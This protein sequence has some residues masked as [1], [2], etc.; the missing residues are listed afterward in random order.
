MR[1]HHRVAFAVL[2]ALSTRSSEVPAQATSALGRIVG[3][4]A[5]SA[6]H[7][8]RGAHISIQLVQDPATTPSNLWFEPRSATADSSARFA[9]DS[10]P[11]G[12]YGIRSLMVGM[13]RWQDTVLVEES[14]TTTVAIRMGES[15]FMRLDRENATLNEA[16]WQPVLIFTD[17]ATDVPPCSPGLQASVSLAGD[18]IVVTGCEVFPHGF[19]NL[20]AAVSRF[21]SSIVLDIVPVDWSAIAAI[22]FERRYRAKILLR[23]PARYVLHVRLN[24]LSRTL[25]SE[26]VTTRIVDLVGHTVRPPQ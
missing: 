20:R 7:R 21:G 3:T 12:R 10:L 24:I 23:E 18:T 17:E 13:G 25:D 4:V 14:H 19:P 11:P 8:L 26:L 2:V 5:D 1:C 15:E 9:F 22:V 6:G 16:S